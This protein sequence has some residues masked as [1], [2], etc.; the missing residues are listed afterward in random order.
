M[1]RSIKQLRSREASATA[2]D[3][4]AASLQFVRKISGYRT[5]SQANREA[6]NQ[7]VAEI[8]AA[9]EKLLAPLQSR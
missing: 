2:A 5:P 3:I 1:C 7:A 9:S 6:F 8:A 4:N